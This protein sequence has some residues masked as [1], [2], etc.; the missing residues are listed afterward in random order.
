M[1]K[2]EQKL[3]EAALYID[4]NPEIVRSIAAFDYIVDAL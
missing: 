3:C 2:V 1:A 4:K